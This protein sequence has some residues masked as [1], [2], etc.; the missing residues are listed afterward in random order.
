MCTLTKVGL[1]FKVYIKESKKDFN[2][3]LYR[4]HGGLHNCGFSG[5]FKAYTY[6]EQT[7][8]TILATCDKCSCY[9]LW[10]IAQKKDVMRSET[11]KCLTCKHF[12]KR[13]TVDYVNY[14]FCDKC[15]V[16][17][18]MTYQADKKKREILPVLSKNIKCSSCNTYCVRKK[19]NN[20]IHYF[21][22]K[23]DKYKGK[24][25]RNNTLLKKAYC[26]F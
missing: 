17:L 10:I 18:S 9:F 8:N 22:E 6:E 14:Y 25:C 11:I 15:I 23:C 12:S 7:N 13:I 21:C 3:P 2:S 4:K 20:V 24:I 26:V 16:S 19:M 1:N 5:E